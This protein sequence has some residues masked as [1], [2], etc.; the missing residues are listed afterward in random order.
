MVLNLKHGKITAVW[1]RTCS[2]VQYLQSQFP[3]HALCAILH[4]EW[5]QEVQLK[6]H[7]LRLEQFTVNSE[8]SGLP[9]CLL[10]INF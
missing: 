2:K 10:D 8:M 1:Y 5:S 3:G 6:V 7:L 4:Q 9:A